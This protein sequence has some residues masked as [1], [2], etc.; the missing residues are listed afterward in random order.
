MEPPP[1][2]W[3]APPSSS[4]LTCP[5]DQQSCRRSHSHL[6]IVRNS[7]SRCHVHLRETLPRSC[8]RD[9]PSRPL[10]PRRRAHLM[11]PPP[12]ACPW[13]PMSQPLQPRRRARLRGPSPRAGLR[14]PP[15]RACPLDPLSRA[16]SLNPPSR[17]PLGG[18]GVTVGVAKIEP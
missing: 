17:A 3:D 10:P 2:I 1:R 4:L 14:D 12:R 8:P 11:G 13:D 18:V 5:R 9:P 7:R 16:C 6:T 15:Q